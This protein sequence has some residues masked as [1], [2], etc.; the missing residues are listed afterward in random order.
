[1]D[2]TCPSELCDEFR[3]FAVGKLKD[4]LSQIE[5][6]LNLLTE[7]QIWH[8]PNDVS[9]AIGNLVIHL[10]G[11]VRQWI[12]GGVGQEPFERDR[13]AEFAQRE[14][15]PT[16][17]ILDGLRQTVDR[18]S[19]IIRNLSP[20]RLL[21]LEEIQKREVSVLAAVFHVVEHFTLHTGQIVYATKILIGEDL[22]LYDAQGQR[23]ADRPTDAV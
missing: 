11:N 8:R 12:I 19:A 16:E 9:N 10:D 2:A 13:P 15:L 1:M 14:P 23:V 7:E 17:Q 21:E 5:R 6:C 4:S 3:R 18:A 20:E 22:S